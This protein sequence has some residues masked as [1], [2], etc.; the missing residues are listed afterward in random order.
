[1]LEDVLGWVIVL[2]GA[3]VMRLTDLAILDPIMSI[4]VAI[5]ILV[6]S[7]RGLKEVLD[8]FL[9]RVPHGV[10][11]EDIRT[12]AMEVEGVLDV[13]HIHLSTMDGQS[14]YATMHIVTELDPHIIKERVREALAAHGVSHTTLELE[15]MGE[16]C[17]GEQREIV[18]RPQHKH[19][20]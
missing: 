2:I 1:M 15:R 12:H 18:A 11:V 14:I 17:H 5:L 8:I 13:H 10:A 3:I 7:L 16:E 9:E 4:G 20:H 19:S 6:A